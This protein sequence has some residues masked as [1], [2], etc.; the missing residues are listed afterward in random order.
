MA[1]MLPLP[2]VVSFCCVLVYRTRRRKRAPFA[3]K[4]SALYAV[5]RLVV[6]LVGFVLFVLGGAAPPV[7]LLCKNV[8]TRISLVIASLE[9][10]LLPFAVSAIIY[11]GMRLCFWAG[12]RNAREYF[13]YGAVLYHVSL[14]ILSAYGAFILLI[15]YSTIFK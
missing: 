1:L 7:T 15:L 13:D 10:T 6:V 12:R 9:M 2:L 14:V 8:A 5:V 11:G 3:E 4:D